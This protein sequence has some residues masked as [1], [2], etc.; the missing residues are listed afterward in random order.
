MTRNLQKL[1][2]FQILLQTGQFEAA[3]EFLS[4]KEAL[5]CHAVHIALVLHEMNLLAL[6]SEVH[7]PMC[8][9]FLGQTLQL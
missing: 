8:R 5:R 7:A 6:P 9:C 3:I 1:F 2:D 4:R